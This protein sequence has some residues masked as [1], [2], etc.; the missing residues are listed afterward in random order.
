MIRDKR[1]DI[2]RGFFVDFVCAGL[3]CWTLCVG[4]SLLLNLEL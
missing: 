2:Q 4:S 3:G 1:D